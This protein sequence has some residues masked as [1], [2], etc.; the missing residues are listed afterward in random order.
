MYTDAIC[1]LV[2]YIHRCHTY[3]GAMKPSKSFLCAGLGPLRVAWGHCAG[4]AGEDVSSSGRRV[5][6]EAG[7]SDHCGQGGSGPSVGGLGIGAKDP[8]LR[9]AAKLRP[10][11]G[12]EEMC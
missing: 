3:T 6:G 5:W 8:S 12:C 7:I 9:R 10:L 2:P 1:M 11:C 4:A